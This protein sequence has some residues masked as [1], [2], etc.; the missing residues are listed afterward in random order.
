M[1]G[2]K[3]KPSEIKEVQEDKNTILVNLKVP[4]TNKSLYEIK[5]CTD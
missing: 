5:G 1:L 4:K 3:N 2:Q